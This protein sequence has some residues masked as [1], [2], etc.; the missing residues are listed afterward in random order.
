MTYRHWHIFIGVCE[1]M[2]MT[3]AAEQL[4]MTQPSVSQAVRE[5]ET[6]YGVRLFERLGRRIYLTPAGEELLA[7]AR[8]AVALDTLAESAMR[9]FAAGG[10]LRI[11]ASVTVGEVLLVPLLARLQ[12]EQPQLSVTSAIHNTA[13]LEAQLLA[14]ALD[15]A[16]VEG[17]VGSPELVQ[18]PFLADALVFVDSPGRGGSE[19]PAAALAGRRFFVRE[20]G[21]GTRRLFEAGMQRAGIAWELAGEYNSAAAIKAAVAA[22]LGLTA[23]SH[24]AVAAE[25]AAGQLA[26][27]R[28]PG[29]SFSR[30]F[31]IV[32]HRQKYLSPAMQA[33]IRLCTAMDE[34]AGPFLQCRKP[35][36]LA[37]LNR[38]DGSVIS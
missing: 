32:Y 22:G 14:D 5:L 26:T 34:A 31:R 27:F 35:G 3:R 23:I 8:R 38:P 7:Y 19:R 25:L 16:L 4:H 18:Q 10:R 9:E 33:V 15:L 17:E 30:R 37:G 12:K 36:A 20:A 2:N 29:V 11:G 1:A 13:E 21:S 28:V 6:H 24:R